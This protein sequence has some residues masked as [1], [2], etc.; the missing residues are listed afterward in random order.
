MKNKEYKHDKK[1]TIEKSIFNYLIIS[2]MNKLMKT[3]ITIYLIPLTV[4]ILQ[5]INKN[6][7]VT[8]K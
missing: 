8:M 6:D 3:K 7:I 2:T 1:F 5:C 4:Q